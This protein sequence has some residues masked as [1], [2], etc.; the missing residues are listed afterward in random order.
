MHPDLPIVR[1]ELDRCITRYNL[2]LSTSAAPGCVRELLATAAA[3]LEHGGVPSGLSPEL[4]YRVESELG[5]SPDAAGWVVLAAV[6]LNAAETLQ[7]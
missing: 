2:D 1:R 3:R 4:V 6:I 5:E 7:T